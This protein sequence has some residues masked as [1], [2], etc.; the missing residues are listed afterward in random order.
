[1]C[2]C[3]QTWITTLAESTFAWPLRSDDDDDHHGHDHW[4]K[5][6]CL[7]AETCAGI[8]TVVIGREVAKGKERREGWG[9]I[10]DFLGC[11]KYNTQ[12]LF[13][14]SNRQLEFASNSLERV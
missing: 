10:S 2:Q 3:L 14:L 12:P 9:C 13:I 1:M 5:V 7:S 4:Q 6:H 11:H 8:G